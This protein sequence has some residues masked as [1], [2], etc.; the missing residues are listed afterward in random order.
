MAATLVACT[1]LA[2][3]LSALPTRADDK[4]STPVPS[5]QG[6]LVKSYE[7]IERPAASAM[8]R[9]NRLR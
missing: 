8:T 2:G 5:A 7:Q 4:V 1:A 3:A 9:T 6:W